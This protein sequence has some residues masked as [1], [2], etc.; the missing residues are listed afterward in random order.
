M[1][2]DKI[3][4]L[5][6]QNNEHTTNNKELNIREEPC[7]SKID[8]LKIIKKTSKMEISS[9]LSFEDLLKND[10][11]PDLKILK[12]FS[13]EKTVITYS[14]STKNQDQ[15]ANSFKTYTNRDIALYVEDTIKIGDLQKMQEKLI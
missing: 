6:F 14:Q 3:I 10:L 8:M 12:N 11:D 13:L 4:D 5:M 2:K 1:K 9:Q 15:N 7:S